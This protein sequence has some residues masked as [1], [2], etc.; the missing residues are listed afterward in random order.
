[1]AKKV[2]PAKKSAAKKA[3]AAPAQP[4]N[5]VVLLDRSGSMASCKEA[6]VT[7]F[8]NFIGEQTKAKHAD[9]TTVTL[10]KF[11]SEATTLVY[12]DKPVS[13]VPTLHLNPRGGTP[14]Y[15]A[16]GTVLTR[17]IDK[18]AINFCVVVTDGEENDSEEHTAESVKKLLAKREADGV[19]FFYLGANQNAIT[20]A[21][22]MGISGGRAINYSTGKLGKGMRACVMQA[23]S[24]LI[25]SSVA[26]GGAAVAY[27]SQTRSGVK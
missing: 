16:M 11:D 14:L 15:D 12:E 22:A 19:Q 27:S 4:V 10:F 18:T 1:M 23:T 17:P 20:A 6:M 7:A 3:A 26:R 13:E 21:T 24:S 8:S 2:K 5:I 9:R 25:S